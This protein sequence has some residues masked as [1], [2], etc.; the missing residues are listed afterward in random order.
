MSKVLL[1]V[2]GEGDDGKSYGSGIERLGPDERQSQKNK[3]K[4]K[5]HN[6]LALRRSLDLVQQSV[7]HMQLSLHHAC[8]FHIV[9]NDNQTHF[10]F[11]VES[12]QKFVNVPTASRVQV[13]RGLIREKHLWIQH[14]SPC[15]SNPLL[16]ASRKFSNTM[17]ST[18]AQANQIQNVLGALS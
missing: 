11:L 18:V 16:L 7:L 14:Q 2:E 13:A 8:K 3:K 12:E 15:N 4:A 5:F 9:G 17:L 1:A 6:S 10:L